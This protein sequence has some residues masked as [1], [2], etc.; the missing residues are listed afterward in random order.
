MFGKKTLLFSNK[1]LNKIV[2]FRSTNT[3]PPF[4][5][6]R[7][8]SNLSSSVSLEPSDDNLYNW[9]LANFEI[10]LTHGLGSDAFLSNVN[11]TSDSWAF[12]PRTSES[13]IGSVN[14][15]RNSLADS[16]GSSAAL[17]NQV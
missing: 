2:F 1:L 16:A 12:M 17:N 11:R 4:M 14:M 5:S 13:Q 7:L 10:D 8:D 9:N 15:S 6:S 3:I